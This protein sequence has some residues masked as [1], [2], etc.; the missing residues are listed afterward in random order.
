MVTLNTL[1]TRCFPDIPPFPS[2]LIC[3]DNS[4]LHRKTGIQRSVTD[5]TDGTIQNILKYEKDIQTFE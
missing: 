4:V 3:H 1:L 2:K 5:I